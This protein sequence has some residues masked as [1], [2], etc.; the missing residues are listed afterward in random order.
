MKTYFKNIIY[1]VWGCSK[2]ICSD[3]QFKCKLNM[4]TWCPIVNCFEQGSKIHIKAVAKSTM[5]FKH[6][7]E[8]E[9]CVSPSDGWSV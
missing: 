1:Y 6:Q 8:P 7:I 5:G 2:I 9:Y 4:S 3:F